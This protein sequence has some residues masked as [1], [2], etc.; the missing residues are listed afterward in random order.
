MLRGLAVAAVVLSLFSGCGE[1]EPEAPAGPPPP[2]SADSLDTVDL[3]PAT[4]DSVTYFREHLREGGPGGVVGWM[5]EN[6][7]LPANFRY[8]DR[9]SAPEVQT[10]V[11][12]LSVSRLLGSGVQTGVLYETGPP[13]TELPLGMRSTT[14]DVFPEDGSGRDAEGVRVS[15]HYLGD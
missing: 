1:D 7:E 14:F 13:L 2:P 6:V 3:C 8:C 12:R 15:F 10:V 4:S 5:R 11:M 9:V